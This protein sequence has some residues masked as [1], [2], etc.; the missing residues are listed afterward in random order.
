MAPRT[1]AGARGH[2][3]TKFEHLQ[4]QGHRLE[5]HRMTGDFMTISD[6]RKLLAKTDKD[7]IHLIVSG[8]PDQGSPLDLTW[9]EGGFATYSA[10]VKRVDLQAYLAQ[11]PEKPQRF[12]WTRESA[13][14][15]LANNPQ[16]EPTKPLEEYTTALL[17]RYAS[18]YK[19]Q[20]Q[21]AILPFANAFTHIDWI[22]VDTVA[23]ALPEDLGRHGRKAKRT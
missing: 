12:S 21:E 16:F 10:I 7:P 5:M 13:T 22:T 15:Y 3:T 1:R 8:I 19:R 20:E 18:F 6:L 4:K 17:K 23:I 9:E 11:Y 2:A 14:E